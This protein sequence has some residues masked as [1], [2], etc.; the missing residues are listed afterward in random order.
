[1]RFKLRQ[2]WS[3]HGGVWLAPAGTIIDANSND[4]WSRR[5][6]GKTIPITAVPLDQEA[7]QAQLQAYPDHAH[8]LG[9]AWR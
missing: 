3:L 8:L 9:G 6:K 1:M 7:W 5:A 4:Q 2:A